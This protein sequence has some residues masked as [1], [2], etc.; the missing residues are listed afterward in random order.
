M[1]AVTQVVN[2]T[3]LTGII[4]LPKRFHNKK[5]EVTVTLDDDKDKDK[6]HKRFIGTLSQES[7]EEITHALL[8]TQKVD[9]DGW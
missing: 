2:S 7:Y 5:V 3:L 1:E 6:P 8:D 4:P 9:A